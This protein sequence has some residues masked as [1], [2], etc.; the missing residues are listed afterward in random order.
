MAS[1]LRRRVVETDAPSEPSTPEVASREESPSLIPVGKAKVSK[2]HG[3]KEGTRKRSFTIIFL[4]GSLFGIIA[5]GFL[6]KSNNLIDFPE[7]GELSMDNFAD[8]LPAGLVRDVRELVVRGKEHLIV[9]VHLL[10][11]SPETEWRKRFRR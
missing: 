11:A 6:A 5:A 1:K 9:C 8:V 7:L 4:L 10:M 2:H 3:H